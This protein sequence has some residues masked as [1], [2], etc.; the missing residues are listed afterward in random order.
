MNHENRVREME[1]AAVDRWF[2]RTPLG[3]MFHAASGRTLPMPADAAE[4]WREEA[5]AIIDRFLV[6]SR[7]PPQGAMIAVI[8]AFTA[9]LFALEPWLGLGGA[10]IGVIVMG[11]LAL[12]HVGDLHRLWRYR[13]N[14]RALRVRIEAALVLRSPLPEE[15]ARR[16]RIGNPWRIA[17]HIWVFG[18]I[19]ILLL[20]AHF[21][22]PEGVTPAMMLAG[23]GAV[24]IAWVLYFLSRR[25]DLSQG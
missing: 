7:P 3:P 8:L 25:I 22:P 17:L 5:Y 2:A 15:L 11:G 9:L 13:R 23:L 16:F 20:A 14:L 1:R 10:Q 18:L 6:D 4:P 21:L 19:A 12:W 24:G